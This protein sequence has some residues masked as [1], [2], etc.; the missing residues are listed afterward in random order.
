MKYG[1]FFCE[2]NYGKT[3]GGILFHFYINEGKFFKRLVD[4]YQSELESTKRNWRIKQMHSYDR[5]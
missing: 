3:V 1:T 5:N 2:R 4:E